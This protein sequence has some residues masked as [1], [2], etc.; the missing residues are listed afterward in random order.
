MTH[1]IT[2]G[3]AQAE[4]PTAGEPATTSRPLRIDERKDRAAP[5][6][7][8]G[9]REPVSA[10]RVDPRQMAKARETLIA[11]SSAV[12]RLPTRPSATSKETSLSRPH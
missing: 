6:R 7:R 8:P 11:L 12:S 5:R 2:R 4:A 3:C 9:G 1:A 10:E